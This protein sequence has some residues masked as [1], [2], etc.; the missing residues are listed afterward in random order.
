MNKV[1]VSSGKDDWETPKSFFEQLDKEFHFTLDPCSSHEN[2]KCK[3]HYTI[4][5]DGLCKSWE[6]E[7][8][9]CNP[10]YSV[11]GGQDKWVKK[12]YEESKKFDT[13]VVALIPAR[14]DTN[15]FHEYIWNGKAKE[16]RFIK[17]RICFEIDGKPILDKNGKPMPAPFPSMVVVWGEHK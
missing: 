8:V 14:T 2:A 3:K 7:T 9:F 6:G 16:I 4:E 10:P 13:V 11:K 5:D 1:L 15:R 17:G 12:C